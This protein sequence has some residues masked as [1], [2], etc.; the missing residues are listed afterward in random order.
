MEPRRDAS[1]AVKRFHQRWLK[2][3]LNSSVQ[4]LRR[5]AHELATMEQANAGYRDG[6]ILT[7]LRRELEFVIGDVG[8]TD[9]SVERSRNDLRGRTRG[10]RTSHDRVDDAARRRFNI[11]P[12]VHTPPVPD[13]LLEE[14]LKA[15]WPAILAWAIEGAVDW[16]R[17]GLVRAAVV[18]NAT[19]DYFT[20]QDSVRQWVEECCET[21]AGTSAIPRRPCLPV[22]PVMRRRAERGRVRRSGSAKFFAGTDTSSSRPPPDTAKNAA[23]SGS[24]SSRRIPRVSGRTRWRQ[25][26]TGRIEH[27][28]RR[29]AADAADAA[30]ISYNRSRARVSRYGKIRGIRGRWVRGCHGSQADSGAE[31]RG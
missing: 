12:F 15:E 2:F 8:G 10:R 20:E 5:V 11:I 17:I 23:S 29:F 18:A 26:M 19:N 25:T 21:E 4:T 7:L 9:W 22:G 28:D 27:R 16:Q 3:L 6:A 30:G 31:L 14:K 13:R 24:G 1:K